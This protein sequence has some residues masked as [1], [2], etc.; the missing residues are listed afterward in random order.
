MLLSELS[1]QH[2][3]I[4]LESPS[5]VEVDGS[6]VKNKE[7]ALSRPHLLQQT[8]WARA[9]CDRLHNRHPEAVEND[10]EETGEGAGKRVVDLRRSP[11]RCH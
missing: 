11:Q 7:A 5:K 9:G 2:P 6:A 8:G 1:Q 3:Q 4:R 10:A